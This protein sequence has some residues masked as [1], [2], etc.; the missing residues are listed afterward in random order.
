LGLN[1][2]TTGQTR[3]REFLDE[4]DRVVPWSALIQIAEPHRPQIKTGRLPP[5]LPRR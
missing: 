2:S 4:M 3:K 5:L 1:R